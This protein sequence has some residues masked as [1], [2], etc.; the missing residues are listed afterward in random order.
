MAKKLTET[1]DI[2]FLQMLQIELISYT[3]ILAHDLTRQESTTW[4]I[5]SRSNMAIPLGK[6]EDPAG[7]EW[8]IDPKLWCSL[9]LPNSVA[10]SFE[11]CNIERAYELEVRVGIT[12]GTAANM[13]VRFVQAPS[14]TMY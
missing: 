12:H 13:K 11:T 9:P 6:S 4:V 1:S 3:K 14:L 2:I 8:T 5:M 7:T 10:P